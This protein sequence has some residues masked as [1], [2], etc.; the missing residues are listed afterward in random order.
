[1]HFLSLSHLLLVAENAVPLSHKISLH[2]CIFFHPKNGFF[3]ER[4]RKG[5]GSPTI[6]LASNTWMRLHSVRLLFR[7]LSQFTFVLFLEIV[8]SLPIMLTAGPPFVRLGDPKSSHPFFLGSLMMLLG[9]FSLG[10]WLI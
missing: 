10:I 3:F 1:M 4:D 8:M 7:H 5:G 2:H 9:Q 6:V